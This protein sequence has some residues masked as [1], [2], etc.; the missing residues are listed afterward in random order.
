MISLK[1]LRKQ[2]KIN[3]YFIIKLNELFPKFRQIYG[4]KLSN[5]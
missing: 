5:V 2:R 4:M 3:I 1:Q